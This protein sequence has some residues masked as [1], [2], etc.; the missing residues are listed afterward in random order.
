MKKLEKIPIKM[1]FRKKIF[2]GENK[3]IYKNY[4]L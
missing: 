4:K 1:F 3:K 2:F